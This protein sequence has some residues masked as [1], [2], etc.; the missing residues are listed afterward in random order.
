M[1][2]DNFDLDENILI[3]AEIGNNHEGSF[4]LAKKMIQ[5]AAES[6]A[7]AV[8]FQTI[9]PEKLVSVGQKERIRQL[10]SYQ[11]TYKEFE[12]LNKVAVN[13][14]VLFLS[15]PFDIESA[16]FLRDLV[17]A[18]KI[19][20]GD[21]NFFPLI[22]VIAKTK[23]PII[24]STGLAEFS[25]IIK[26]K[27]FIFNIWRRLKFKQELAVLH[28]VTSYP[29]KPE[30]ANL[31]AI[32]TLKDRLDLTVGYSDH[33]L[34]IDA[35]VLSV[36]LGARIIEKH[37]TI[38]KN[39]SEFHDHKIAAD[40]KEFRLMVKKIN[41]AAKMMGNGNKIRQKSERQIINMVRR[42]ITAKR[43][44][45]CGKIL[46]LDD[47]TWVRPS[48]G[49]AVGRESEIIGKTLLRPVKKGEFILRSDVS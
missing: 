35:A 39:Y 11:F 10:R 32:K 23:K 28:C 26:T 22:E 49:L 34:G 29:V 19:S 43:N 44:L 47:I 33:T 36:A 4:S 13:E 16:I 3:V 24:L 30:E 45:C 37:F 25:D 2:I 46:T 8:K 40:P 18:F 31:L 12:K 27:N 20:S 7:H 48:C 5:L 14:R 42:S 17:P 41:E 1:K 38:D 9:V 21:N 6:G 15:T